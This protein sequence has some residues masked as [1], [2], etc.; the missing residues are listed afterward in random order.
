VVASKLFKGRIAIIVDGTPFP[1]VVEILLMMLFFQILRESSVRLPQPVGQALS[2][3]GS[4]V[5]GNMDVSAGFVSE[6][7]LIV[8]CL[9][10]LSMII[11]PKIYAPITFWSILLILFSSVIGLIGYFIGLLL[12]I[13]ELAGLKTCGFKYIFPM[14]SFKKFNFSDLILR[15]DLDSV[16][17]HFTQ[18]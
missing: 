1:I 7:T 8:V 4:I 18:K 12:M 2:I 9:S 17:Q 3:V 10:S 13:S 14:G 16:S 5:L 15:D 6:V 11:T